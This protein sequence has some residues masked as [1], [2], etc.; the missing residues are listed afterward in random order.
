M[1]VAEVISA[2][3]PAFLAPIIL[4]FARDFA[5]HR[6]WLNPP[7][8]PKSVEDSFRTLTKEIQYLNKNIDG[9]RKENVAAAAV[10]SEGAQNIVERLNEL[11]EAHQRDGGALIHQRVPRSPVPSAAA[12]LDG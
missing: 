7:H 8:A 3:L 1:A 4:Y 6:G 9:L 10:A 5:I 12:H 11:G 2:W